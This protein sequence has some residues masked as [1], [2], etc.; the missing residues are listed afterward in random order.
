[1]G[2]WWQSF[3]AGQRLTLEW[4]EDDRA[5]KRIEAPLLALWG[6][7]GTVGEL[8]DVLGTWRDK[9]LQ[10]SGKAL[11]CGHLLPEEDP[12]STLSELKKFFGAA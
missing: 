5:G 2:D 1:M 11:D 9:A 10:V 12:G 8:Y 4:V 6:A 7:K 3:Q